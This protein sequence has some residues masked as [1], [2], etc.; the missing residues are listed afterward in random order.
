MSEL[1]RRPH[2]CADWVAVCKAVSLED[3]EC[4]LALRDGEGTVRAVALNLDPKEPG[5]WAKVAQLEV[6]AQVVLDALD[7]RLRLACKRDVVDEDRDD[8]AYTIAQVDPDT[9]LTDE[10]RK[11][12]LQE[13][14]VQL[15]VPAT[16]SLLEAVESLAKAPH[17][18]W[19]L[20]LKPLWLLHV[21]LLLQLAVEVG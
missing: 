10:A 21:H 3:V 5:R 4:V 9:V 7:G 15:L 11:S 14:L 8:D 16:T 18:L 12:E 13:H 17:P 1:R 6:L 19:R 2:G 20:L